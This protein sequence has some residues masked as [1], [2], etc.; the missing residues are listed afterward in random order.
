MYLLAYYLIKKKFLCNNFYYNIYFRETVKENNE[1]RTPATDIDS[2]RRSMQ[3]EQIILEA[4]SAL[5]L[6]PMDNTNVVE[7]YKPIFKK[8]VNKFYF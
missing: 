2:G 3:T 4:N 5:G 7:I 1:I 6:H 8:N